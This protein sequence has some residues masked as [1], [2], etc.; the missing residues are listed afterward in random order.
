MSEKNNVAKLSIVSNSLLIILKILFGVFTGSVSIMSEAIHSSV[1][2]VAAIIA[3]I[4]VK[5]SGKPAD[6]AHPYGHGK[7]ENVSGVIEALLIFVAAFWIIWEATKKILSGVEVESVGVGFVVMFIS[8]AV[9]FYVSGKLYKASQK[10]DSIALKADA[11][12]LKTDVY[13]SLGVGGGLL[14]I[15]ITG[16]NFLDPIVAILVALFICKEAFELLRDAFNPILDSS[17]SEED[18]LVIKSI[19]E[20]YKD[21]YT[22]WH[23]LRTRKAG[24][25]RYVDIH[26]V[27]DENL[28]LKEASKISKSIENDIESKLKNC[29]ILIKLET[30]V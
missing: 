6:E 9:N 13:T 29:N 25:Q 14:I 5:I 17:L 28:T 19:M 23:E 22:E 15:W 10:Y 20:N 18:L 4:S 1:D 11:L 8:A 3:F 24:S 30:L 21:S 7:M 26:L 16:L 27:L 2:L 12:H